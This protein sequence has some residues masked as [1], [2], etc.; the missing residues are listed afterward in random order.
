MSN[1]SNELNQIKNAIYGK[2]VRDAIHDGIKKTYD[3]AAQSGNANMEVSLARGNYQTLND[4]LVNV[5]GILNQKRDKSVDIG[6]NDADPE[7]LAAIEGGEDTSFSLESIPRDHS[8]TPLKTTFARK[9]KNLFSGDYL[10]DAGFSGSPASGAVF[11]IG[12]GFGGVVATV[13]VEPNTQYTISKS[14]DTDYFRIAAHHEIPEQKTSGIHYITSS[15]HL[16]SYTLTTAESEF[17]LLIYVS[18]HDQNKIPAWLQVEEGSRQTS[19]ESPNK[20]VIDFSEKQDVG[21]YI[22][23]KSIVSEQL[24]DDSVTARK[25]DFLNK[26]KNLFSGEYVKG[27][28]ISGSTDENGVFIST[29]NQGL[30]AIEKIENGKTYTVSRIGRSSTRFRLATFPDYPEH[31]N[32]VIRYLYVSD[33]FGDRFTFTAGQNENYL[34]VQVSLSDDYKEPEEFM[35]EEGAMKTDYESPDAFTIKFSEIQEFGEVGK[36]IYLTNVLSGNYDSDTTFTS[37]Y[38]GDVYDLYNYYDNYVS[39]YPSYITKSEMAIEPTGLPIYRYDFKPPNHES[40]NMPKFIINA[41]VHGMEKHAMWGVAKFFEDLCTNWRNDDVLNAL[42]WNIHFIVIPSLNPWGYNQNERKNSNG[43]DLNRNFTHGWSLGS[44]P[45]ARNYGGTSPASEIEVQVMEELIRSNDD[46]L[47]LVDHHN[48]GGWQQREDVIWT[49]SAN[50]NVRKLLNGY[51]H[52]MSSMAKRNFP[53]IDETLM[54]ETLSVPLGG[55]V[56]NFAH[57][58]GIKSSLLETAVE[59]DTEQDT[60]KFQT[61]A[62]GNLILSV[63]KNYS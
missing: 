59:F 9:G 49:G 50:Q 18:S 15:D 22:K 19:F 4:R 58:E 40:I 38:G 20:V 33:T 28:S 1:I 61:D 60:Q 53:Y 8:V 5:D 36:E 16:T 56:T 48:S 24:A 6:L 39:Q 7:M 55:G 52:F 25:V 35:I 43:I 51:N 57:V 13:Q 63:V 30:V 31:G 41:G 26:G 17:Y 54:L 46:A 47:F 10:E 3:D 32:S 14:D 62:V 23:P 44:D 29:K 27:Y 37:V 12:G 2:D 21:R 34:V 45:D 11:W 42:R